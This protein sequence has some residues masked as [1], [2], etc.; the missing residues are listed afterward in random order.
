MSIEQNKRASGVKIAVGYLSHM[1]ITLFNALMDEHPEYRKYIPILTEETVRSV[2]A[3]IGMRIKT[4][5]VVDIVMGRYDLIK[6]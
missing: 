6:K 2:I 4:Q 1:L 3:K 5:A